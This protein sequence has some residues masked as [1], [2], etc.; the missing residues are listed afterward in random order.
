MEHD[1]ANLIR[2]YPLTE[3][4]LIVVWCTQN[5]GLMRT[6]AKGAKRPKSPFAGKLDLFFNCSISWQPARRSDLHRLAETTVDDF[7]QG[8]RQSYLRTLAASYFVKL[9]EQVVEPAT[10]IPELAGLLTRALN[11]LNTEEP[12]L[13]ALQHFERQV[14][15]IEGCLHPN[16]N[17]ATSLQHHFGTL[18]IQRAQLIARLTQ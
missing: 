10:P 5:H 7:R 8:L 2:T 12:T 3:T 18:P 15:K 13:R 6:A 11:Y 17:P 1:Q 14:S 9:I 16:T 4:S